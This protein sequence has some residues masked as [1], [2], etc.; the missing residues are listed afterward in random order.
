M[1]EGVHLGFIHS[2]SPK[3]NHTPAPR[4]AHSLYIK[5]KADSCFPALITTPESGPDVRGAL[6]CTIADSQRQ[7]EPEQ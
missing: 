2:L 3:E 6:G 1:V 7:Q 4:L 5:Y